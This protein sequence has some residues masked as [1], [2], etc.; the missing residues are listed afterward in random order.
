MAVKCD[1]VVIANGV[2]HDQVVI[3]LANHVSKSDAALES[4][5]ELM[6]AGRRDE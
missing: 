4:A 5:R 1:E 6:A 3:R 2:R